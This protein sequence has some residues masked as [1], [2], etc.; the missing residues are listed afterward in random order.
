MNAIKVRACLPSH[1][2]PMTPVVIPKA[3]WEFR[4][5]LYLWL[6]PCDRTLNVVEVHEIPLG[7]RNQGLDELLGG[8]AL[9][10]NPGTY[11]SRCE[12]AADEGSSILHIPRIIGCQ[13]ERSDSTCMN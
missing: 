6:R 7:S 11:A 9:P 5:I 4:D 2:L 13:L 12:P 10:A 3:M 8:N 1:L